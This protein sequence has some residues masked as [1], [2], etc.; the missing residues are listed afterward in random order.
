MQQ[1]LPQEVVRALMDMK[2]AIGYAIR[3]SRELMGW[4]Q[5][6]L[7]TRCRWY[8]ADGSP[9]QTRISNYETG[10]R[11]P[12]MSD[13]Q[14]IAHATNQGVMDLLNRAPGFA[15]DGVKGTIAVLSASGMHVVEKMIRM[16]SDE[17]RTVLARVMVW[18]RESHISLMQHFEEENKRRTPKKSVQP[19]KKL[20]EKDA[21]PKTKEPAR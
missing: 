1:S 2:K 5:D 11:E 18:R 15:E 20:K 16:D 14:I 10:L 12:S 17:L 21:K 8:K 9:A 6:Q 3:Q 19:A 4:N 13:L 7:A